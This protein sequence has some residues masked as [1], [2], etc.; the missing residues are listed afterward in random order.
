MVLCAQ[1]LLNRLLDDI[2]AFIAKLQKAT[3]AYTD[4]RRRKQNKKGKHKGPGGM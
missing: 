1:E 2:E 3:E 4:L